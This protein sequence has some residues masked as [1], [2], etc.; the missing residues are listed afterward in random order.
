MAGRINIP[1]VLR[2]APFTTATAQE[3][4]LSENV[5]RGP[6]FRRPYRGVYVWHELPR[7]LH[8]EI[9]A[10][11]LILPA[12]AIASHLTSVELLGAQVPY[13]PRPNFWVPDSCAGLSIR[14]L[15]LHNYDK[16]P[17]TVDVDGRTLT[18]ASKS[19]VD[20]ATQ[21]D[22]VQLVEV[23]DSLVRRGHTTPN[24]LR[25]VARERGRRHI[26]K[27][28]AAAGYVCE[29]VDSS[30]ETRTR[31]LIVLGG[32][33]EPAI[34]LPVFDECGG[35]LATPDLSYREIRVAVEYDGRH[36]DANSRQWSRDV[37]RNE[38]L[39]AAGWLIIVVRADDLRLRPAAT[40]MRI[41]SALERRGCKGLP[42]W[43]ADDWTPYFRAAA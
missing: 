20:C 41:F 13:S 8:T 6:K 9:D 10:A 3:H 26:R 2:T 31:M 14:G 30:P 28:R 5:L 25:T 40:L 32:L 37:L 39:I 27:A 21:L 19:F 36:H 38:N 29:G 16:R 34:G 11:R 17:A 22:L 12:T 42:R 15:R 33:P 18:A 4:H 23:G 24:E 1:E 43:P 7:T 35:W